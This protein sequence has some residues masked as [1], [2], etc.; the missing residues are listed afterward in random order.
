MNKNGEEMYLAL[1]MMQTFVSH[2]I[3][4]NHDEV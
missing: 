4:M 1:I 3:Y 2:F